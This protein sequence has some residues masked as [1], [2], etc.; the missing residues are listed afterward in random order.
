MER[1]RV[2]EV[3]QMAK[4]DSTM[5]SDDHNKHMESIKIVAQD[6][7]EAQQPQSSNVED[8]GDIHLHLVSEMTPEG[9]ATEV[10][11]TTEG[12]A[13][14]Y[15]DSR[16]RKSNRVIKKRSLSHEDSSGDA[17]KPETF[18][19]RSLG[20]PHLTQP[21]KIQM[22]LN[23]NRN[24]IGMRSNPQC[25]RWNTFSNSWTRLG[26][27]TEV[28]DFEALAL[29]DPSK[30]VLINCTCSH[31][32]NYAVLVDIIDPE[33]IPEPSL[34]VQISSYSAFMLSLPILFGVLIAL[35][36]LRGM[37]TN[38]N[39]IHQNLVLCVFV[40]ELLFFVSMQARRE[41]LNDEF[42][43]KMIAIC[44]HYAWLAAFAWTT[45]DC[46]H[47]YR[48]LTE[49]RDINHGPMGFYFSMGYGAPA[50]IVGLSVGVRAHEYGNSQL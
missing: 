3:E 32:S 47:L 37:Q 28:P 25:V 46:I 42:S 21:I 19:Y 43:C 31:V 40:A 29:E 23:L 5:T 15:E 20:S 11:S 2:Q 33:D 45:V 1:Q 8:L 13:E 17:K 49:M 41:L 12:S 35:A 4:S 50:I 36:L 6:V 14:I 9:N 24:Q 30:P 22:W 18:I 16:E 44:L 27:Q 38:S 7:I 48:M 26:C 34:L 39:T 10:Q